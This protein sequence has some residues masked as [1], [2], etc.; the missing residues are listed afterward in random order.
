VGGLRL[1]TL[2]I[3]EYVETTA[4][5]EAGAAIRERR[6]ARSGQEPSQP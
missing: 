3:G 2:A 6:P 5:V 4:R 1:A